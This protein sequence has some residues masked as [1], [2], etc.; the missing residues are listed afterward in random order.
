MEMTRLS[1]KGQ[2]ILPSA[3]RRAKGWE[4]GTEFAVEETAEGI[5]L[6]PVGRFPDTRLK[7]VVGCLAVG[8]RARS[9]R[10]MEM[11]VRKAIRARRDR[12]RY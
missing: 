3:V 12:G 11:G 5:L 1:S 9:L 8:G 10:Q 6:R 2:V 7:D 4:A